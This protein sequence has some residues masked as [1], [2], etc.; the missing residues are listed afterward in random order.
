MRTGA[1]G[2]LIVV[3]PDIPTV[4]VLEYLHDGLPMA[5]KRHNNIYGD[6]ARTL[7]VA[8]DVG[9]VTSDR[10]GVS[11]QV[12]INAARLLEAPA[13]KTTIAAN[14]ASLGIIVSEF[15]YQNGYQARWRPGARPRRIR[16][17]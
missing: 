17:K 6:G 2:L 3:P 11:G 5:L 13:L 8:I 9:P 1:T 12:I 7:K 14:R 4:H 10:L 15:I 16:R